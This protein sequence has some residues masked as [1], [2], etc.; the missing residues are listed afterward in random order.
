MYDSQ[1]HTVE[2]IARTLGVSRPTI[3]KHLDRGSREATA[4]AGD[5]VMVRHEAPQTDRILSQQ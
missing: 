3:Y 4:S 5:S 1:L 2:D